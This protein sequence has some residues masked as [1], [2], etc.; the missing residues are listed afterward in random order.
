[1]RSFI[2]LSMRSSGMKS[3][4]VMWC[5][6]VVLINPVAGA[7]HNE[8]SDD[9]REVQVGAILPLDGSWANVGR[10]SEVAL[11]LA[12]DAVNDHLASDHLKIVL[13]IENS[14]SDPGKALQALE[15]FH[16]EG[17]R[18][19]IGP[20]S[21]AEAAAVVSYAQENGM[22]LLSPSSTAGSLALDDNLFRLVPNDTHQAE[23]LAQLI[24]R[25]NFTQVLIVYMNDAYGSGMYADLKEKSSDPGYGFDII[26]AVPYDPAITAFE[27]LIEEITTAAE[28]MQA[29]SGAI[30]L[31]GTGSQGA[32]IFTAA[33]VRSPLSEYKWFSGDGVIHEAEVLDTAASAEF[34]AKTRLEGFT[35]ACEETLTIIPT[36]LAAGLMSA[37]LGTAPSPDALPAWDAIWIIAETY[38]LDPDADLQDFKSNLRSVCTRNVNVFNQFSELDENGDIMNAKYARFQAVKGSTGE[39]FWNLTGMFIKNKT[40]GAFITDAEGTLTRESGDVVIGAVLPITGPDAEMGIGAREAIDL[41]LTHATSYYTKAAG[42]D[43]R[44]VFDIRDS[45]SDPATTLAQVTALHEAGVTMMILGGNSADLSAAREYCKEHQIIVLGTRSTAVTLADADDLIYRLTPDDSNQAKALV[46]LMEEQGKK[47]LV[48]LYRDDVYG[49]GLQ[50]AISELFTGEVDRYPY[51]VPDTDFSSLVENATAAIEKTGRYEETA[52]VVIGLAEVVRLLET[53]EDGPLTSVAWYG[54]DGIAQSR[55]L[56]SSPQAASTAITTTLT[57][58]TYDV[59]AQH[60]FSPM[61]QM[62]RSDLSRIIGEA[63]IG[64]N[65]ISTYDAAWMAMNAYALTSPD[66]DTRDLWGVINNP[67]GTGGITGLYIVN[68][69]QD[70]SLSL[71]SFYTVT[72][73][74]DQPEW[75]VTAYYRDVLI[76]RDELTIL[77]P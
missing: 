14:S 9:I 76:A 49:Q 77:T 71:Y 60:V 45:A 22:L 58:A 35:F 51:A 30:V 74:S 63:T 68:D 16:A 50:E 59:A 21:S 36:M 2:L 75:E 47:H 31:I 67:Y 10:D 64:W 11:N 33:G 7:L 18:T 53:V 24:H 17:I 72:S 42:L 39:I 55:S 6:L 54:T 43:I 62:V 15:K 69:A 25:Q 23:A 19:V 1:M 29:D 41:A 3:L 8:S 26:G 12:M 66:A 13:H 27:P 4:L 28:G 48:I 56:L 38:R 40:A 52:V 61:Y 37:E 20:C 5:L 65:E 34:A 57:C 70:Q 46:R 73:P 44:F 32:G